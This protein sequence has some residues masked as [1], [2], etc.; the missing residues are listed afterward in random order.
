M[1]ANNIFCFGI[2]NSDFYSFYLIIFNYNLKQRVNGFTKKLFFCS[3]SLH[4]T[5]K[6]TKMDDNDS[7]H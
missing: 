7:I 3:F 6:E 4:I 5:K 1:L 2:K